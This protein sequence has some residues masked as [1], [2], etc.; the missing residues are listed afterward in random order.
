MGALGSGQSGHQA[1]VAQGVLRPSKS[2][3]ARADTSP[4]LGAREP[5]NAAGRALRFAARGPF[6]GASSVHRAAR[7]PLRI[8]LRFL[9]FP[10]SPPKHDHYRALQ[11]RAIATA[12]EMSPRPSPAGVAPL[13]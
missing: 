13:R 9:G 1:S 3:P 2:A 6:L 12:F 7:R 10:H 11:S 5:E 4:S 8:P